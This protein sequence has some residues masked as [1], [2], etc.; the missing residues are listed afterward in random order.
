MEPAIVVDRLSG[1]FRSLQVAFEDDGSLYANLRE[2]EM[3]NLRN[4][5][6]K[7]NGLGRGNLASFQKPRL[8]MEK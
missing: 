7:L 4:T 5:P 1:F 8:A 6:C 3:K 2:I